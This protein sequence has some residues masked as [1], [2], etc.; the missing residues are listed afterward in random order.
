MATVQRVRTHVTAHRLHRFNQYIS[1]CTELDAI[2]KAAQEV[3]WLVTQPG[4]IIVA[5]ASGRFICKVWNAQHYDSDYARNDGPMIS[6]P[7]LFSTW[8]TT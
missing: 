4:R 7:A 8:A 5:D 2:I 6:Q 3:A 1:K